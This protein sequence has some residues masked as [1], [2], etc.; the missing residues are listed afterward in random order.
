VYLPGSLIGVKRSTLQ[1]I[2][3]LGRKLT[4]LEV[5]GHARIPDREFAGALSSLPNLEHLNLRYALRF[6]LNVFPS[7]GGYTG[8]AP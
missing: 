6:S 2:G 8:A 4:F 1:N 5:T 3:G 7:H